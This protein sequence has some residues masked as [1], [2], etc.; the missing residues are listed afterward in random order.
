MRTQS[1]FSLLAVATAVFAED[2]PV[3][4][5]NPVGA[6]YEALIKG[7]APYE[8]SGSVKIA[9]GAAGMG[10]SV[11][12]ALA[13]LPA[14]G[15]PFIYHIHEKSVPEDGNC[16]AT[17]AHLDPYKRGEDPACDATKPE[18]CQVG[19]LSG[20]HGKITQTSFS[21][22]YNDAYIATSTDDKSFFGDKSIVVH[23]AN[24]TRIAC[25]NFKEL[26][27]GAVNTTVTS[28]GTSYGTALPSGSASQG[29]NAT[30]SA[31]A[32]G[33]SSTGAPI[34]PTASQTSSPTNTPGAAGK[35]AVSGAAIF[36][37]AAALML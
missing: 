34:Q 30:T 21:A 29:H 22:T 4:D 2:A 1:I 35:V 23:L 17:G 19:D 9:S 28:V 25:A 24:K 26:S 3:V 18:S 31:T 27:P 7:K 37:F 32:T 14:E 33:G 5:S 12:I 15:G 8:V 10:V 11:E 16:T 36:A 20:K 13:N 6:Q